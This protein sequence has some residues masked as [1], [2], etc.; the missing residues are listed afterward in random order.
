MK[1]IAVALMSVLF[2]IVT[3]RGAPVSSVQDGDWSDP[4]T[5]GGS[6][7]IADDDVTVAHTVT[8]ASSTAAL[9]SLTLT[10]GTLT[11]SGW[12]TAIIAH[13]V[14][15]QGGTL[16]HSLQGDTV[17]TDGWTPDAR[18][19]IRATDV[20]VGNSALITGYAKGYQG[21]TG[22]KVSTHDPGY[23]PGRG[24]N[25]RMG[26]G[27]GGK[28]GGDWG[29]GATYGTLFLVD[30]PGSGGG[31]SNS[32]ANMGGHGG[33]MVYIE[34]AGTVTVNG[35]I[36]VRGQNGTQDG[37]GGAGGGIHIEAATFAGNG[38]IYADGRNPGYGTTTVWGA[39]GG[40]R[41]V[42]RAGNSTFSGAVTAL[43]GITASSNKANAGTRYTLTG[44][45]TPGA[46][47]KTAD[48]TPQ[49]DTT[50]SVNQ[51]ID[52]VHMVR[53]IAKWTPSGMAWTDDS[54][55]LPG[56]SLS[57]EATYTP[58]GLLPNRRYFVLVDG[59]DIHGAPLASDASGALA[60]FAV[61]LDGPHEIEIRQPPQGIVIS[62]R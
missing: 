5:W 38:Y 36:S 58:T 54:Q 44:E 42:L 32:S 52:G 35:T 50:L 11:L 46:V 1:S 10:A 22:T 34:A 7:P 45:P 8:L 3:A 37:A 59:V 41:V 30:H 6:V 39:G 2:A 13:T 4:G 12:D 17:S 23:G 48:G 61:T 27:F 62:F 16:T 19:W 24:N 20:T 28:G 9:Q 53:T 43:A 55:T 26:A 14:D 15:L 40:G 47:S 60:A 33:G 56:A 31:R 49:L 51:S 57:N 29:S 18:V 25:G 21:R